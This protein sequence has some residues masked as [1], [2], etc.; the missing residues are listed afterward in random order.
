MF[1]KGHS[2]PIHSAPAPINVRC[3]SNGAVIVG[4]SEVALRAITGLTGRTNP[5]G[6]NEATIGQFRKTGS[7][8][9][10]G[11][12]ANTSEEISAFPLGRAT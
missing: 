2:R 8:F 5:H 3:Y 9:A 7:E 4:R 6:F 10:C 12:F 1:E 11:P